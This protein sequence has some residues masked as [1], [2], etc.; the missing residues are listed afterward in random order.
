MKYQ[1]V[2]RFLFFTLLFIFL[3]SYFIENGGYYEYHLAH[4]RDLT[5]DQIQQFESD[6]K[7][8]KNI[9]LH[10]YLQDRK[11]DYS[12]ELTRRTSQAS[13]KVNEY[14]KTVISGTFRFLEK[15]VR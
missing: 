3:C 6:V 8:G 10:D 12:S 13:L 1:K 2:I 14:L 15:L 9:D 5:T 7:E 11:I 4:R